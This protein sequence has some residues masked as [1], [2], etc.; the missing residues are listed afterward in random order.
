MLYQRALRQE[1]ERHHKLLN[2]IKDHE[3]DLGEERVKE[4][5][6]RIN[7]AHKHIVD[8]IKAKHSIPKEQA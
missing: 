8:L 6:G 3:A 7:K 1:Q 5:Y 2:Y 4:E